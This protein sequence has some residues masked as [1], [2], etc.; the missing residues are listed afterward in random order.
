MNRHRQARSNNRFYKLQV[1]VYTNE[2]P[3]HTGSTKPAAK[4]PPSNL[5]TSDRPVDSRRPRSRA[6]IL[7]AQVFAYTTSRIHTPHILQ[8]LE[9]KN[10]KKHTPIRRLQYIHPP[11]IS[12]FRFFFYM[13]ISVRS[14]FQL[15]TAMRRHSNGNHHITATIVSRHSA[16]DVPR[17]RPIS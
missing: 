12:K 16:C 10:L 14:N 4:A 5:T 1:C 3:Q 13:C 8:I 6:R 15:A 17:Y 11:P 2:L 7:H 9:R